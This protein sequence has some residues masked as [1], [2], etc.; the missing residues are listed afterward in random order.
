MYILGINSVYHESSACLLENGKLVAVV[1]EER[2]NRIKHGKEA[3]VDNPHELPQQS[4]RHCLKTAGITMAD[5]SYVGYST[6]PHY[7]ATRAASLRQQGLMSHW[8]S[9]EDQEKMLRSLAFVPDELRKLGFT[10]EF[11]WIGH[12]LAHAASAFY[13]SP[14]Q[15]AAILVID[16]IG[17]DTDTAAYFHG[18][19]NKIRTLQAVSYPHS[20]GFLWELISL[21]LG[22]SLYDAAKIMG[23]ASYGDPA[24]YAH[25]FEQLLRP[26]ADGKFELDNDILRFEKIVYYPASADF[27][28]VERLLGIKARHPQDE[29]TRDHQDI[30]AALQQKT[31]ELVLHIMDHLYRETGS[32]NI[33]LAGGVALNC[34][35]NRYAFEAGPFEQLYVQAGANDAGTAMGAAAHIWHDIL[36]N[37]ARQ[38]MLSPYTGPAF[39][40]ADIEAALQAQGLKYERLENI[41]QTVAKLIAREAVVGYFQGQMEFGPR[42]LGSR[43]ILA[44]PRNANMR[45]ILNHKVKHREYFRPFAPSV[46]YEQINHWFEIAKETTAADFMLM[47][48]PAKDAVKDKI[49]A[50]LHVDGTGRIQTVKKELS[51]RYHQV[52]SEFYKLTGIPLVLNTSFNDQ[53]PII[54]TPDD[55]I[56]TFLKTNIDYLAIGDFLVRKDDES[57]HEPNIS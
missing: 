25:V 24:R 47:A 39:T 26:T 56:N 29:L 20:L 13:A 57:S 15:E 48:Y 43:S 35:T 18:V 31:N 23:L 40:N 32:K 17:D 52:I 10:G 55:A 19:N 5:V 53:E 16:G 22:F 45:E 2:F 34:V 46:L 33:C 7:I 1:E 11:M 38:P 37:E 3:R 41:E 28:G 9:W 12:H 36:G 21:F 50:V 14:F 8:T 49:P 30:A 6:N 54:C 42:A 44:D 4:I 51:P 27:S